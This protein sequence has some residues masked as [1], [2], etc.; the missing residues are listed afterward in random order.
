MSAPPRNPAQSLVLAS[1]SPRRRELLRSIGLDPEILITDV[2]ETPRPGEPA[3]TLAARLAADKA[4][5]ARPAVGADRLL[6]AADTVVLLDGESLGKPADAAEAREMLGRLSGRRH[7]VHTA[8]HLL[9]TA[10]DRAEPDREA[11]ATVVTGVRFRPC[12]AEWIEGYV[13]SGEPFGKAGAYAIQGL[14]ALLVAG[15]EGSWS[16][17]VG[18]PLEA[19]PGL[20]ADVGVDLAAR[21]FDPDAADGAQPEISSS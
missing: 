13:A 18:L 10:P 14:G 1:A 21:V 12:G 9:R 8:V 4:R 2:D 6:L 15:I 19:L 17:V 3:E 11:A 7:E 20:F 16:N 5:A